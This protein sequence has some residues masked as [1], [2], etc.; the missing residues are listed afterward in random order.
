MVVAPDQSG[1]WKEITDPKGI[2]SALIKEYRA[3][4]H[5]TDNTPPMNTPMKQYLG[6][7]GI[8]EGGS[9]VLEG[10][11]RNIPC[12]QPYSMRLL[13]Q[14]R[15]INNFEPIPIGMSATE[16]SQG[17]KKAKETRSSGGTIIHFG[18]CKSLAQDRQLSEMEASFLSIPL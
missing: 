11:L 1:V 15:K 3:K 12:L 5:Q 16:Y 4:Y 2:T 8:S 18:H 9:E 13:Q 6:S 7:F 14:L 10:N 17:W